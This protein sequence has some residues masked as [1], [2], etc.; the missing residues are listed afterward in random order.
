MTRSAIQHHSMQAPRGNQKVVFIAV[1]GA[2]AF[3]A[4]PFISKQ[5]GTELRDSS[6][7]KCLFVVNVVRHFALFSG[8]LLPSRC[9]KGS[10]TLPICVMLHMT[11][12]MLLEIL[13]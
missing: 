2:L 10:K 11:Q 3:A 4:L 12:R 1:V 7:F 5:V 6:H 9:E 13:A 8:P